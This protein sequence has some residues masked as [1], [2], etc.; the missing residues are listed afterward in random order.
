MKYA[1]IIIVVIVVVAAVT[2]I[3]IIIP[4]LPRLFIKLL[5]NKIESESIPINS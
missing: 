4:A 1:I 5:N 3:I 2:V